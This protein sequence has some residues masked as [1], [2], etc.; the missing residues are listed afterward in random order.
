M[1]S[2]Q[3]SKLGWTCLGFVMGYVY[4]MLHAAWNLWPM[5]DD[6]M[7]HWVRWVGKEAIKWGYVGVVTAI[8]LFVSVQLLNIGW[9]AYQMYGKRHG[10]HH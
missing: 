3:S 5:Q 7:L 6:A 2:F 1:A 4:C 8:A 10:Q 9:T